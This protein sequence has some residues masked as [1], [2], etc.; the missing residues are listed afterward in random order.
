LSSF[1][2]TYKTTKVKNNSAIIIFF[3]TKKNNDDTIIIFFATIGPQDNENEQR[4]YLS[5]FFYAYKVT[6]KDNDGT[7]MVP[8]TSSS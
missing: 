5:S 6:K 8:S 7:T 4:S 2:R 1:F 3:T